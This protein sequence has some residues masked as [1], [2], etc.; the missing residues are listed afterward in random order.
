MQENGKLSAGKFYGAVVHES[1]HRKS[2]GYRPDVMLNTPQS[3]VSHE[4]TH[5]W[6]SRFLGNDLDFLANYYASCLLNAGYEGS[7]YES[8]ADNARW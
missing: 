1:Q 3:M 2:F 5:V 8:Q 4:G 6:Q 7:P